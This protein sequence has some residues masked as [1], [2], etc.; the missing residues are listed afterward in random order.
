MSTTVTPVATV[1]ALGNLRAAAT[2]AAN[3]TSSAYT[4]DASLLDHADVS[5]GCDFGTVAATAG[6]QLNVYLVVDS[7]PHTDTEALWTPMI[8]AT[9][10]TTK[11]K[12]ITLPGGHRYSF[13]LTN[14][15]GTNALSNAYL[16]SETYKITLV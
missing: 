16:T 4:L 1:N 9:A 6:L 12:T 15:D 2:L 8:A 11:R 14:L 5:F 7:T 3:T 10:S 13:T